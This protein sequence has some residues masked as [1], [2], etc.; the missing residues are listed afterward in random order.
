[1][2]RDTANQV[3]KIA[4]G[5]IKNASSKINNIAWQRI[6]QVITQGGKEIERILPKVLHGAI[7][8]VY[9]M[10]F[11]LL[12]RF[13]KEQFHKLKKKYFALTNYCYVI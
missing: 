13:G 1:M 9:Q 11:R 4:L 5:L 3:G 10:P 12:R 2:F 6:N 7:D 8:D